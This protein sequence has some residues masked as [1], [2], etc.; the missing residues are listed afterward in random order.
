M[1][2]TQEREVQFMQPEKITNAGINAVLKSM[3]SQTDFSKG[4]AAEIFRRVGT[5]KRIVVMKNNSPSAVILSPDEYA[6]LAEYEEDTEL[7]ALA[8]KR[9]AQSDGS[10]YSQEEAMKELGITPEE[11]ENTPEVEIE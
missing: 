3:V 7:L 2:S 6:R 1:I 5:E 10:L 9:L 11:L 8:E 4:K